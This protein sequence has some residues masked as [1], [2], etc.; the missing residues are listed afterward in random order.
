MLDQHGPPDLLERI[1]RLLP[2]EPGEAVRLHLLN[3]AVDPDDFDI[4]LLEDGL[5]LLKLALLP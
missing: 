5:S 4:A 2:D 3:A 1:Q